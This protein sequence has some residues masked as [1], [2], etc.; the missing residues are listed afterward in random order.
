MNMILLRVDLNKTIK[1]IPHLYS[2]NSFVLVLCLFSIVF[3]LWV[4]IAFIVGWKPIIVITFG[5][6]KSI[7]PE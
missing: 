4:P 2:L 5:A 7:F 6:E 1:L 3:F